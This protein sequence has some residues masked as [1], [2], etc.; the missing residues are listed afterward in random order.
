M[1]ACAAAGGAAPVPGLPGFTGID[2]QTDAAFDRIAIAPGYQARAFFSWGDPVL[3]GAPVWQPDAADDWQ[4]QLQQAGDNHDG[5]HYFP[6]PDAPGEH[7]LLVINHEFV[8]ATLHPH[9]MSRVDGKRPLSEVKKEQA[10]HGVSVIEIRKD[11]AGHWQRVP[12]S[13][14]NRRLSALTPMAIG[15][16][17]AGHDLMKT[18]S[19][20]EGRTVLGTIANCAMGF[21]PWGTYL[22]CEENWH[23]YFV[24]RDAADHARRVSHQRYGISAAGGSRVY[25]WETADPRF[26]ATPQAGQPFGGHVQEPHRFG[27][28]VEFDPF[29]PACVPVKRT[30][31]GRF[32]RE[33]ASVAQGPDG[34][35]A[36][37]SGDDTKGEY[38]YKFVPAG[39]YNPN[40]PAANR[41]LLDSGTLY[42]AQFKAG[43][44]GEWKALVLGQ[45][46]LVPA[47][48]F[49][50]QEE[51]LLNARAAADRAGATPMDRPE[52]VAVQPQTR[53]VYVN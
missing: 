17:L 20:P 43:G 19:D 37:Y 47:N 29:D 48:G 7:G 51:I 39:R 11:T 3:P 35:L 16:P 5:M 26:D 44:E 10:A 30:A 21:T 4:A 6:F 34:R 9:G 40:D 36:V 32:C 12:A 24:N 2:P 33:G 49:S 14:F 28:V 41:N 53:E 1:A 8:S 38:I 50:S 13:R 46:G 42:A 15:G 22:V 31:L 25:G 23:Q 18:A 45:N 27:W 52:W